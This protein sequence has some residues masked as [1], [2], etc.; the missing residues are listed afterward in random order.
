MFTIS[1]KYGIAKILQTEDMVEDSCKK[2][3]AYKYFYDNYV[4][5]ES[6]IF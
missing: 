3:S 6:S 4:D 1:G 5:G 2:Q